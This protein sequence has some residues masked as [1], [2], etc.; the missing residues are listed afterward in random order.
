M[1]KNV[2]G[3][4]VLAAV[5]MAAVLLPS[6]GP[7]LM[8]VLVISAWVWLATTRSGFVRPA[9]SVDASSPTSVKAPAPPAVEISL[10]SNIELH[11]D[12]VETLPDGLADNLHRYHAGLEVLR[13]LKQLAVSDT[14][15]SVLR[16]TEA[17]FVL[18]A[19]SKEVSAQIEKS[20]GFISGGTGLGR[21][22]SNLES[23]VEVFQTLGVH[24]GQLKEGLAAD[25]ESLGKAVGSIN[26]F[27]DTLSDLADQTNVLAINASIEAARVGIH[28]R[29]F[30][31]IAAQVQGLAKNSKDIAETMAR[32]IGEVVSSVGDSFERQK[33]RIQDSQ[34]L[35]AG[36]DAQLRQW[37]G[38]AA[39]QL[40]EA[41]S[42]VLASRQ[43]SS[44][45]TE[46]LN[47]VTVSLQFQDRTKQILDHLAL[48][49]DESSAR[50][51]DSARLGTVP[52]AL[53]D[54]A[55]RSASRHFTV[56]EEWSLVPEGASRDT[57]AGKT[58]ELF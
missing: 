7:W 40:A 21:T 55:L 57:G 45:V 38:Q 48:V 4:A 26:R 36:S 29:G 23:Q 53:R 2:A 37:A 20:L 8:P 31:V 22:L 41:E 54:E 44:A 28:G 10:D 25:I 49:L 27:S 52:E 43:L 17:L 19:N 32:T 13:G 16:L 47:E 3:S 11:P 30:A 18:V 46:Q 42:M 34:N 24:F 39:P 58:V 6:P 9:V 35:I 33:Q 12:V 15:T 56:K 5:G 50:V 51:I 14:E 1:N